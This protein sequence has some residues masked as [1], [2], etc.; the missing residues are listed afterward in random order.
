MKDENRDLLADS[1]TIFNIWKNYFS[2]LLNMSSVSDFR[3]IKR[4]T[5]SPLLPNSRPF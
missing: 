2:Q 5:A 3:Q 1:H 4:H